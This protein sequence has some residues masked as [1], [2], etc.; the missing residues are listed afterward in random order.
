MQVAVLVRCGR[1]IGEPIRGFKL[2]FEFDGGWGLG[3]LDWEFKLE[4]NF[5]IKGARVN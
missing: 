3:K 2:G 4:I 1:R 5:E